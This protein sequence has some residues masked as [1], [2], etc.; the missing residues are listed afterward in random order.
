MTLV[1]CTAQV[2]MSL[3]D[4]VKGEKNVSGGAMRGRRGTRVSRLA[5]PYQ[6]SMATKRVL[7]SAKGVRNAPYAGGRTKSS[8]YVGNLSW[9]A[10]W[11]DLKDHMRGPNQDL[12]VLH[13]DIMLEPNGSSKGCALVEYE[14][15]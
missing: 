7:N 2:D 13:A 3:D 8:V 15:R 11:Q 1:R 12:N 4:V 10:Q 5:G 6:R 9:D 14:N